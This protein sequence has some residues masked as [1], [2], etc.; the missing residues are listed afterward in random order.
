M[1]LSADLG[2]DVLDAGARE[3]HRDHARAEVRIFIQELAEEQAFP[4]NP[5]TEASVFDAVEATAVRG[6]ADHDH[7]VGGL[8]LATHP[9]RPA[10]GGVQLVEV[11]P[12]VDAMSAEV[13]GEGEYAVGVTCVRRLLAVRDEDAWRPRRRPERSLV[14]EA[15]GAEHRARS[16]PMLRREQ[17]R[18]VVPRALLG[19]LLAG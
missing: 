2:R 12:G 3:E 4:A 10:L 5:A 6:G 19:D 1:R 9:Q 11:E 8:D 16:R 13:V 15:V 7:E 17:A 14:V 18:R